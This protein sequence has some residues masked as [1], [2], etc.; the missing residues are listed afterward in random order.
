MKQSALQLKRVLFGG[1]EPEGAL[2]CLQ[3]LMED[4][5]TQLVQMQKELEQSHAEAEALSEQERKLW[6]QYSQLMETLSGQNRN[7]E[8]LVIQAGVRQRELDCY[9]VRENRLAELENQ[10]WERLET[11]G[12]QARAQLDEAGRQSREQLETAGRQSREQLETAGRQ[13]REQLEAAGRQIEEQK[14]EVRRQAEEELKEARRQ[15][16]EII[17]AARRQ[18]EELLKEARHQGE[19]LLERTRNRQEQLTYEALQSR[20][21][22]IHNAERGLR[23]MRN[24]TEGLWELLDSGKGSKNSG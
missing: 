13:S 22:V 6:M 19:E 23:Q 7:M 17:K 24:L 14:K 18:A 5:Q 3:S 9:H 21:K 16:E 10:A 11:A 12:R 20:K 4:H 2:V 15:A 8:L 1:Y